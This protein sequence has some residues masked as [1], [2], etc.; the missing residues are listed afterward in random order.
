MWVCVAMVLAVEVMEIVAMFPVSMVV[1]R[2]LVLDKVVV[3]H[4]S[5]DVMV[6]SVWPELWSRLVV[7]I[8]VASMFANQVGQ[9]ELS[10]VVGMDHSFML[11]MRGCMMDG[12][13]VESLMMWCF[14]VWPCV[15]RCLMVMSRMVW[16]LMMRSLRVWSIMMWHFHM[17]VFV[18]VNFVMMLGKLRFMVLDLMRG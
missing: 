5:M 4:D 12:L 10:M 17:W 15:V 11:V 14:M 9:V 7:E 18:V 2:E 1:D 16:C 13:M 3:V 6:L 8:V